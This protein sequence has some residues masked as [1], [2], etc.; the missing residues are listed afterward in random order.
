MAEQ[1][2]RR[3]N[4]VVPDAIIRQHTSKFFGFDDALKQTSGRLFSLG[5][6]LSLRAGRAGFL[7]GETVHRGNDRR[8]SS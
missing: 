4:A 6:Q 2:R 3:E 1:I 7:Y 8:L 5:R